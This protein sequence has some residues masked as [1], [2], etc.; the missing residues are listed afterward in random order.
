[1]VSLLEGETL[2]PAAPL[3]SRVIVRESL[4]RAPEVARSSLDRLRGQT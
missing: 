1:V 4:G 3:E 2:R